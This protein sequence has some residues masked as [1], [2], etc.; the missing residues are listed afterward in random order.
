MSQFR[1]TIHS[2]LYHRWPS[3]HIRYIVSDQLKEAVEIVNLHHSFT[4]PPEVKP[5]FLLSQAEMHRIETDLNPS[6][7][8]SVEHILN[9]VFEISSPP[10][11]LLSD[12]VI[13]GSIIAAALEVLAFDKDEVR[14]EPREFEAL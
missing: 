9:K 13:F 4:L 2:S 14:L 11:P 12:G 5:S 10:C 1:W 6:Q 3:P 8:L 7:A